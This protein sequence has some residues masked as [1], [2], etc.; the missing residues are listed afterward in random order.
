M[1]GDLLKETGGITG[2]PR[3]EANKSGALEVGH[4]QVWFGGA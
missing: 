3:R 1:R 2:H 4:R